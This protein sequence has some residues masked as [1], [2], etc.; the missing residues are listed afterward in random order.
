M[1]A[2]FSSVPVIDIDTDEVE[3]I[4][5]LLDRAN[6]LN[7]S[8][9]TS[10]ENELPLRIVIPSIHMHFDNQTQNFWKYDQF[11]LKTGN[12]SYHE[13]L[14]Q[15][16]SLIEIG[17]DNWK[18]ENITSMDSKVF[19]GN[20]SFQD[21]KVGAKA[22]KIFVDRVGKTYKINKRILGS[23]NIF[24]IVPVDFDLIKVTPLKTLEGVRHHYEQLNRWLLFKI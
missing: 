16:E 24:E 19:V 14:Q 17:G 15:G 10:A 3:N 20:R 21:I 22:D 23:K 18:L 5:D 7:N 9:H 13:H 12:E 8:G 4:E 2:G 11:V 6:S 1:S